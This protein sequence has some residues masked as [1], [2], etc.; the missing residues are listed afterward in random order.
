[1]TR[2][3]RWITIRGKRLLLEFAPTGT[4]CGS[5]GTE[6]WG[7]CDPPGKRPRRIL[8]DESLDGAKLAEILIHELAH[9]AWWDLDEDAI[10]EGSADIAREVCRVLGVR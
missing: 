6:C 5:D 10:R 4:V 7:K 8:L 1:M 9:A 3:K 2:R